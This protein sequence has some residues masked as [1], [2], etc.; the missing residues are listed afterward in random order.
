MGL[1]GSKV[2][3]QGTVAPGYESVKD[4]FQANFEWVQHEHDDNGG[5]GDDDD[6]G[7]GGDFNRKHMS[8]I[9]KHILNCHSQHRQRGE[10]PAVRLCWGGQGGQ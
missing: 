9:F 3:V 2:V 7:G 6:D 5:G 4:L 10:C 1:G 8:K